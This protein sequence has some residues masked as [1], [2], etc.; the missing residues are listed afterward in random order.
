MAY[1]LY[2]QA[3][4]LLTE[5]L[6][7]APERK[8]L[9]LKLLEVYFIWENAAGFLREAEDIQS[10]LSGDS[11]PDWN[12]VL[13]MG[14][15]ICPDEALFSGA[16]ESLGESADMDLMLTDDGP[17]EDGYSVD[18]PLAEGDGPNADISFGE[19]SGMPDLNLSELDGA[20]DSALDFDFGPDDLDSDEL[21][22]STMETPT[23]ESPAI[24]SDDDNKTVEV[25]S[26]A[27]TMETPTVDIATLD[28]TIESPVGDDLGDELADELGEQPARE[29]T[30]EAPT[31]DIASLDPTMAMAIDDLPGDEATMETPTVDMPAVAPVT[32]PSAEDS[33]ITGKDFSIDDAGG[34]TVSAGEEFLESSLDLAAETLQVEVEEDT[35]AVEDLGAGDDRSETDG[36][37]TDDYEDIFMDLEPTELLQKGSAED[38]LDDTAEHPQVSG[39]EADSLGTL[40]LAEES[41]AQE[42]GMEASTMTEVGTKLDLAR[43]YIDMGD[44]DGA[45]SILNEVLEEAGD[46]QRQEAQQLLAGLG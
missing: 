12:K 39:S 45:R 9:R 25:A 40:E 34:D 27:S 29:S 31:V 11:D 33:E 1:G 17:S 44:P 14:K 19:S 7:A 26:S 3:A 35:R 20:G 23:I 16:T 30:M 15:Q 37:L 8:D 21:N 32:E 22:A 42:S 18:I 28:S 43:A 13:I 46:S 41:A 2:D 4:D 5:E 6:R 36:S 24:D 10:C 38:L